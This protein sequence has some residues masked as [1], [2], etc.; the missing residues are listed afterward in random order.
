MG[1][2]GEICHH[3]TAVDIKVGGF[4]NLTFLP[5]IFAF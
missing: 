1:R 4:W 3:Q 5:R 2:E